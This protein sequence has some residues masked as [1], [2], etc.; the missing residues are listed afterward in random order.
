MTIAQEEECRVEVIVAQTGWL[1]EVPSFIWAQDLHLPMH[2]AQLVEGE[3]RE[4]LNLKSELTYSIRANSGRTSWGADSGEFLTV[5]LY[6]SSQVTAA[7]IGV[8]VSELYAR[9]RSWQSAKYIGLDRDPHP[10]SREEV[11]SRAEWFVQ[12]K[13]PR[14]AALAGNDIG[15][16]ETLRLVS[17]FEDRENL[18]WEVSFQAVDGFKYSVF[19][20]YKPGFLMVTKMGREITE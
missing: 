18:C 9:F 1:G 8:A 14:V 12:S 17:E 2:K 4:L 6:L 10:P 7:A 11:I 16:L 3:L 15:D 20:E 19:L 13:Y 5:V